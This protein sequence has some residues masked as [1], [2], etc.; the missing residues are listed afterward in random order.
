MCSVIQTRCSQKLE[1]ERGVHVSGHKSPKNARGGHK[2]FLVLL[3]KLAF[4]TEVGGDR[5]SKSLAPSLQC[6]YVGVAYMYVL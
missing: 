5:S 3:N 1:L 4:S 6:N 2:F